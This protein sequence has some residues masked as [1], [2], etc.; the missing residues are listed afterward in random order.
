MGTSSKANRQPIE[1]ALTP[2]FQYTTAKFK[3]QEKK[4]NLMIHRWVRCQLPVRMAIIQKEK[5]NSVDSGP[6]TLLMVV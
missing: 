4:Q 3:Q 2:I 1:K 6:Y 5:T